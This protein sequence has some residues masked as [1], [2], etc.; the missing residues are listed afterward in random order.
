MK[1]IL[2]TRFVLAVCALGC[3]FVAPGAVSTLRGQGQ[4]GSQGRGLI[5]DTDDGI[6]YARGQNVVPVFEGWVANP[7]G[8]YGLIFGSWNRNWEEKMT[9]P[10]G[11]DNHIEPGPQ[12]QGQPTFFYPRRGKNL[13]EITVPK[14]FGKKEVVWTLV[15]RGKTEK[16]YG[17][18]VPQEVLSRHMVVTG[19]SL[20][21]AAAAG[22]DDQGDERDPNRPP[23][24]RFDPVEPMSAPG[25]GVISATVT[26]DGLPKPTPGRRGGRGLRVD[27]SVYRGPVVVTFEP[28]TS[29]LS[30][31]AGGKV[32]TTAT[33]TAPGTY[34]LRAKATDGGGMEANKD[35]TVSVK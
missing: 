1:T 27:W 6:K 12:D 17:A 19:G 31:L 20:N 21:D 13:F 3:A 30:A 29:P 28:P 32:S 34:V 23:A 35:V 18:L 10:I 33:F 4:P 2:K 24:V 22:N 26:D 14:D 16:A 11:P 15:S 5:R 9:I 25:R 7:D 8:T